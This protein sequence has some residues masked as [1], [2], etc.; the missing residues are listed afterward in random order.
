MVTE[1]EA[2][3][4]ASPA[5]PAGPVAQPAMD[6]LTPVQIDKGDDH[7]PRQKEEKSSSDGTAALSQLSQATTAPATSQKVRVDAWAASF[8]CT[9]VCRCAHRLQIKFKKKTAKKSISDNR[10]AG[11]TWRMGRKA[12][13]RGWRITRRTR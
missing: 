9:S 13:G 12:T 6:I 10:S 5:V 3:L 8:A 2:R 11:R 4:A 1:Y 7:V